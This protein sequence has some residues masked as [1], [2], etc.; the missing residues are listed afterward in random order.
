[1]AIVARVDTIAQ[2]GAG[3][4]GATT[5]WSLF[6][7]QFNAWIAAVNPNNTGKT[8]TSVVAPSGSAS[9]AYRGVT[10]SIAHPTLATI[11][12][13]VRMNNST[14]NMITVSGT[15]YTAGAAN[16]N[17]GTIT[18]TV[19]SATTTSV[20]TTTTTYPG[21][22]ITIYDD[23]VGAEFFSCNW[24]Q[25][26]DSYQYQIKIYKNTLN[27]WCVHNDA[28]GTAVTG[29]R[30][31]APSWTG[32]GYMNYD[33]C[34]ARLLTSSVFGVFPVVDFTTGDYSLP[35]SANPITNRYTHRAA[36]PLLKQCYT[37]TPL[38][39]IGV[40]TDQDW[41]TI[42]AGWCADVTGGLT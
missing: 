11:Y 25:Y 20:Y 17:H 7:S 41:I 40:R 14:T 35:G 34:M 30:L 23:T 37:S 1:M 28:D 39:P 22:V 9:D 12:H 21:E 27:D 5:F 6:E 29:N 18:N 26:A 10:F 42:G 3:L 15:T 13:T 19:L 4:G 24:R 8:I 2:L 31:V 32:T 16:G 33:Y 36:S 38:I